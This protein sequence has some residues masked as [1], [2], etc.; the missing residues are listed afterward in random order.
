MGLVV[1]LG[2]LAV[3]F[4]CWLLWPPVGWFGLA[5]ETWAELTDRIGCDL[6]VQILCDLIGVEIRCDS[7]DGIRRDLWVGRVGFLPPPIVCVSLYRLPQ[8]RRPLVP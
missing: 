6:S 5:V 2:V 4:G 3:G 8:T 1:L 7:M